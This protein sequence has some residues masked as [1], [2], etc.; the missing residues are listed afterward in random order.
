MELRK[1]S[2]NWKKVIKVSESMAVLLKDGTL[3]IGR[4]ILFKGTRAGIFI[5]AVFISAYRLTGKQ[6]ICFCNL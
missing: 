1:E 6:V 3:I 5:S 2:L 4:D